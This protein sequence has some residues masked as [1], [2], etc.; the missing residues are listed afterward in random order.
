MCYHCLM[1]NEKC[2]CW[3][4]H[5][6][7]HR[8]CEKALD[9]DCYGQCYRCLKHGCPI[10][11]CNFECYPWHVQLQL[12]RE[13]DW[14]IRSWAGDGN[15]SVAGPLTK[16]DSNWVIRR[17]QCIAR[18]NIKGDERGVPRNH[19]YPSER[20]PKD[21]PSLLH[22][23]SHRQ[24]E[25][26][27]PAD[28]IR[29][30]TRRPSPSKPYALQDA[31]NALDEDQGSPPP[32]KAKIAQM[33][34]QRVA[35]Q[36]EKRKAQARMPSFEQLQII[37]TE[38]L[39]D[40]L[41]KV[42]IARKEAVELQNF[43]P[44]PSIVETNLPVDFALECY[45]QSHSRAYNK[46]TMQQATANLLASFQL[47]MTLPGP[48][49][50]TVDDRLEALTTATGAV[51]DMDIDADMKEKQ[52]VI[53][54]RIKTNLAML[55]ARHEAVKAAKVAKAEVAADLARATA[56]IVKTDGAH[57]AHLHE[58]DI[59]A[60]ALAKF[61]AKRKRQATGSSNSCSSTD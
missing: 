56:I 5:F 35:Q 1:D 30:D 33:L 29:V 54:E 34:R 21:T 37:E 53:D 9:G 12:H 45:R 14:D 10:G 31:S 20:L 24:R 61:N 52:A 39:A 16:R 44:Y 25:L 43:P 59:E 27:K 2:F 47:Q 60:E 22:I 50:A 23:T 7:G 42:T 18:T 26:H 13:G 17:Q 32:S 55:A 51:A 11:D 58:A 6:D 19:Y 28:G 49:N 41:A 15:D 4:V 3:F 36:E 8:V 38:R 46:T 40:A 48:P 57:V